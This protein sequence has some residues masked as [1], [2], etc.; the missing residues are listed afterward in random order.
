[1]TTIILAAFG[2]IVILFLSFILSTPS[3][4][5]FKK[6]DQRLLPIDNKSHVYTL[7]TPEGDKEFI[8]T[9]KPKEELLTEFKRILE[10]Y[11]KE[12]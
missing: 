12:N 8:I 2:T 5:K 1:M 7:E 10:Q 11:D 3:S 6:N 4:R 9:N